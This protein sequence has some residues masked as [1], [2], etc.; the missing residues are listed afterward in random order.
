MI[1]K[2]VVLVMGLCNFNVALSDDIKGVSMGD[3]IDSLVVS[4]SPSL[5]S[6]SEGYKSF[7][8]PFKGHFNVQAGTVTK[9]VYSMDL[10]QY[11]IGPSCEAITEK[12][13]EKYEV[14]H[15]SNMFG[16]SYEKTWTSK[17]EFSPKFHYFCYPTGNNQQG[18]TAKV[19][20]KAF[21]FELRNEDRDLLTQRQE[22]QEAVELQKELNAGVDLAM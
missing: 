22:A 11:Y 3:N 18:V 5:K 21:S 20:M 6:G 12:V 13:K 1:R 2:A 16:Q 9:K 14:G 15:I 4:N 7:E 19:V 8:L 10:E 17:A